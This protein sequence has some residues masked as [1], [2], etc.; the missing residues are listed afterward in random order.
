MIN[1]ILLEL[2]NGLQYSYC[3]NY[4]AMPEDI[5]YQITQKFNL[6]S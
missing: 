1:N 2:S 4:G 3:R 5:L 6:L